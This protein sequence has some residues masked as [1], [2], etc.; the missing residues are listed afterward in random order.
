MNL[1]DGRCIR[2]SIQWIFMHF[3]RSF[4]S[5]MPL[6]SSLLL[7]FIL[8]LSSFL[9]LSL[10]LFLFSVNLY[11][12]HLNFVYRHSA[13]YILCSKQIEFRSKI[14][15]WAYR[16]APCL[17]WQNLEIILLGRRHQN[18]ETVPTEH[19]C[20]RSCAKWSTFSGRQ[21]QPALSTAKD[22]F[23]LSLN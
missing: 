11:L 10:H 12:E 3:T 2:L 7:N 9:S 15:Y 14:I 16:I 23:F 13:Y 20:V 18:A 22:T 1:F 8:V 19:A 6:T 21:C 4:L 17:W 5:S